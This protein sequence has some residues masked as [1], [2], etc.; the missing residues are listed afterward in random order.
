MK[1][2]NKVSVKTSTFYTTYS[3][4]MLHILYGGFFFNLMK[5]LS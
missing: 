1:M 5:L 4:V 3:I 2:T